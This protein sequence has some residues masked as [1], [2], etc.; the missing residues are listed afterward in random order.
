M[1]SIIDMK[2]FCS[3]IFIISHLNSVSQ[4]AQYS[5]EGSAGNEV[6]LPPDV[7]PNN[8][9]LSHIT[10]GSGINPS[11]SAGEFSS[12]GWSTVGL[13]INDY[14]SLSIS[15]NSGFELT[16][17]SLVFDERRSGSGIRDISVRSS[18]D[19]FT[20]DLA[21]LKVPDNSNVR[22]QT[23][24]LD[25]TFANLSS[26]VS[27]ELRIYGYTAESTSGTW[28]LDNIQLF[29]SIAP[30]DT[31]P[32][33]IT[34]VE[35]L[36]SNGINIQFSEGVDLVS[37][38]NVGNYVL[39]GNINPANAMR[40]NNI[41][42]IIL[43]FSDEFIDGQ[44]NNI[45]ASGIKDLAGNT[46]TSSSDFTFNLISK[47]VFKDVVIN[48]IM[49]DPTPVVGLA[50]AEYVELFNNSNKNIDLFNYTLNGDV[51]TT[52]AYVLFPGDLVVLT[53]DS[54]TGV[55][56]GNVIEMP[57]MGA[58]TNSGEALI[59]RDEDNAVDVD[60]VNYDDSWYGDTNKDDGGYS[61]ERIGPIT[62][63]GENLS[64]SA[65]VDQ[66]GGTPGIINSVDNTPLEIPGID[67]VMFTIPD[68][69]SLEIEFNTTPSNTIGSNDISV[70]NLEVQ[71]IQSNPE[72]NSI[73][74][75]FS[76]SLQ[77]GIFYDLTISGLSNCNGSL[78]N[79]F[80]LS[81]GNGAT[82]TYNELII[83]EIM[84][85]PVEE[86]N[87]PDAEYI[88]VYNTTSKVIS[89]KSIQLSDAIS[90]TTLPASL[91]SPG[92][93][94]ILTPT[95]RV[96]ELSS[97][98]SVLGVSNW[99]SLNNSG[100]VISLSSVN[101]FIF[102]VSYDETWYKDS[103]KNE[104]GW[105]LEMI[106]ILNPCGRIDNWSASENELGGSPGK[107]NSNKMDNPDNFGPRI[108]DAFVQDEVIQINFNEKLSPQIEFLSVNINPDLMIGDAQLSSPFDDRIT[109]QVKQ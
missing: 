76:E 35:V 89:L 28:W 99:P 79:D 50:D 30:P 55:F 68:N 105:S 52:E 2:Y 9:T 109:F 53:D 102:S 74:I 20:N 92:T 44:L 46:N 43:N 49:A 100:D 67:I 63:C 21:T 90:T 42:Q 66:S 95:S 60:L 103:D 15:A 65:S 85:N 31:E 10:R 106:D 69:Q 13:D 22:T 101:E 54:N 84:A 27:I 64:W 38:E 14:Y 26:S 61:L 96:E 104:G 93:Y 41:S 51:I 45:V 91:I 78:I 32:P 7:P 40:Q 48:E 72:T 59:L 3:L 34:S 17:T 75:Q 57:S 33:V 25:G 73:T 37:S 77:D 47:A 87:L 70:G 39:N 11:S 8:G 12:N 82:P 80:S 108:L 94:L 36:G 97:L 6:S 23:V 56:T 71:G 19:A 81:F 1:V 16:I 98:G 83:T 86:G 107:P 5:F 4:I 58:L 29:G 24:D 18:L 88:E 62:A